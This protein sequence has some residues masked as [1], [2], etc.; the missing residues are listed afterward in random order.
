MFQGSIAMGAAA[1]TLGA[2]MH[3]W[4]DA[5]ERPGKVALSMS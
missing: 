4:G 2:Q 1:W 5:V 3:P